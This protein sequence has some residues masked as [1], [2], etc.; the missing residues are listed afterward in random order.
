VPLVSKPAAAACLGERL[1]RTASRPKRSIRWDICERKSEGPA[2]DP[3][4]EVAL[5]EGSE[6]TGFDVTDVSLV[7]DALRDQISSD[8]LAQPLDIEAVVLV[9]VDGHET[10]GS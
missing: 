6:F 10:G 9:V 8:Q 7:D 5:G 4:E 2:A 3:S 1:A